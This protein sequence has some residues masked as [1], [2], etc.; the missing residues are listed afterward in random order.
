MV[1]TFTFKA[2]SLKHFLHEFF[3][4]KIHKII[5]EIQDQG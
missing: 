3:D 4:V 5:E 2:L 1:M